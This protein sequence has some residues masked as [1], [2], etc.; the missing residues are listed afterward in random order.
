M[1]QGQAAADQAAFQAA[2]AEQQAH[3]EREAAAARERDFRR[4]N[5]ALMAQRRADF[6]ARGIDQATG[7]SL[8]AAQ[9]FA[10]EA[11][12]QALRLRHGGETRFTRLQQEASLF[13]E[14]GSN[15]RT[16]G[17]FRAGSSLLSGIGQAFGA[18]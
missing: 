2:Q 4:S 13:R 10:A 1:K 8:L 16:R 7:S 12:L 11:E 9:D 3:A 14:A 17:H 18:R 5:S 6:G 15:A